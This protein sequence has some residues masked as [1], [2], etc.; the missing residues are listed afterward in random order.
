MFTWYDPAILGGV[1]P[2]NYDIRLDRIWEGL[3]YNVFVPKMVGEI[4]KLAGGRLYPRNMLLNHS[5]PTPATISPL[6]MPGQV[7]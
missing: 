2:T 3:I 4:R 5:T 7:L 6:A 1:I